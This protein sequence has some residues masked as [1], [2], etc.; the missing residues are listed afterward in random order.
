[1]SASLRDVVIAWVSSELRKKGFDVRRNALIECGGFSHR[2]DVL[3]ETTVLEN[4]RIRVGVVLLDKRVGV[5]DVEKAIAW[6]DVLGVDKVI[7]VALDGVEEG[8]APLAMRR[9]I[10][11]VTVPENLLRSGTASGPELVGRAPWL[12]I[13][14]V[15]DLG[16]VVGIVERIARGGFVRRHGVSVASIALLFVPVIEVRIEVGAGSGKVV[17]G[18]VTVEG[19]KGYFV[20][21]R[22]RGVEIDVD[23]GSLSDIPSEAP[24]F[25][26]LLRERGRPMPLSEVCEALGLGYERAGEIAEL[27]ERLGVVD[28]YGDIVEYRGLSLEDFESLESIAKRLG[29]S[30][31]P[32]APRDGV[33]RAILEVSTTL[34][35]LENL[36]EAMDG[37]VTEVKTVYY[38]LYVALVVEKKGGALHE[39]LV[40]IDGLGLEEL[41]GFEVL[42]SDPR[43]VDVVKRV[44]DLRSAPR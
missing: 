36:V 40:A 44:G 19:V 3:A 29:A 34:T 14:P 8:V 13:E 20:K 31:H 16:T 24:A 25:V 37:K 15:A 1:M 32:G 42:A 26:K 18:V 41:R 17:E 38:P 10:A 6:R 4:V 39:K 23:S 28:R 21:P 43:I 12:H 2:F 7:F 27:L 30:V 5:D 35:P 9:G 22:N 33:G 11:V